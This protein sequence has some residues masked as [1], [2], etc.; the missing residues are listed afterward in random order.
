MAPKKDVRAN[1]AC[2]L[3]NKISS[4]IKT[5]VSCKRCGAQYHPAC[6][7]KVVGARVD[8][9]GK[10]V[11]CEGMQKCTHCEEKDTL[12]SDL[13]GRLRRVNEQSLERSLAEMSAFC[14]DLGDVSFLTVRSEGGAAGADDEVDL[15]AFVDLDEESTPR[16]IADG[17]NDLTSS[18]IQ[19]NS[20]H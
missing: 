5:S 16:L 9:D 19:E 12:I 2:K 18:T 6:I 15:S 20:K 14:P 10:I 3:C 11:C 4:T 17:S 13:N 1:R 8:I 7:I